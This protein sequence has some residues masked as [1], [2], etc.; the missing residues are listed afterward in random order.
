[1]NPSVVNGMVFKGQR[2]EEVFTIHDPMSTT[3][4][5]VRR[6]CPVLNLVRFCFELAGVHQEILTPCLDVETEA[7]E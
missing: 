4:T 5:P 3:R 6:G 7:L 2:V 1:M